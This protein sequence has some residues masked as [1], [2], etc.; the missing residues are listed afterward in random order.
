MD[1]Y[2]DQYIPEGWRKKID[3]A[4]HPK[5]KEC[6]YYSP[7][8]IADSYETECGI[9]FFGRNFLAHYQ[10]AEGS[11]R[12]LEAEFPNIIADSY[13][14]LATGTNALNILLTPFK[15]QLINLECAQ[16]KKND[17]TAQ[18]IKAKK[19]SE[20]ISV[21]HYIKKEM[22][23]YCSSAKEEEKLRELSWNV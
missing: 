10:F 5:F 15:S 19:D 14:E 3:H 23:F 11:M 13:Y 21:M 22:G 7:A 18:K 2:M 20:Y 6:Y 17:N 4:H 16:V 8:T 1:H 12:E 9:V